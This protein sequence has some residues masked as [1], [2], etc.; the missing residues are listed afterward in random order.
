MSLFDDNTLVSQ[1]LDGYGM[2]G[3]ANSLE[4]LVTQFRDNLISVGNSVL[5]TMK[6]PRKKK[7]QQRGGSKPK[8]TKKV[9]KRAQKGS[10]HIRKPARKQKTHQRGSGKKR[11]K[12]RRKTNF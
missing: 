11:K 7:V 2:A 10:G 1:Q 3:V 9:K 12:P 8:N 4:P 5:K 6:S